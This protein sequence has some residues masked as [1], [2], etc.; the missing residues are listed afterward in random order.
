VW[1][2]VTGVTPPRGAELLVRLLLPPDRAEIVTGDLY[3]DFRHL[4]ESQSIQVAR[5]WYWRQV[6]ATGWSMRGWTV[7]RVWT[8]TETTLNDAR[9]AARVLLKRPLLSGT[10]ITT[11]ALGVGLNS[12]MFSVMDGVLLRPLP[13]MRPERLVSLGETH[14]SLP[15]SRVACYRSYTEW[16]DGHTVFS[17]VAATRPDEFTL[18]DHGE[19]E[20]VFGTRVTAS[21]FDVLGVRPLLGRGFAPEEDLPSGPKAIV[22]N[23]TLWRRRFG[24]D[25]QLVGSPVR[26]D[27]EFRRVVGI[28]PAAEEIRTLGWSDAW[29]PL[30]V[31]DA[32][33]RRNDG[34]WLLVM[35]RLQPGLTV[36]DADR[37]LRTARDH[38]AEDFPDSYR[39]WGTRVRP[40]RDVVVSS[41][42][43]VV[44][45]LFAAATLLLVLTCVN[46]AGL[47]LARSVDRARELALRAAIGAT[48]GRIIR[49]L[50]I[51]HALLSAAGSVAGIAVAHWALS[52]IKVR[53]AS[54]IPR[55]DG[56]HLDGGVLAFALGVAT[57]AALIFGVGPAVWTAS[58]ETRGAL[59]GGRALT[60][61]ARTRAVRRLLVVSQLALATVLVVGSLLVAG[62]LAE[63][64]AV[65]L[66]FEAERVLHV[67]L[68]LP[69]VRYA[70]PARQVA[71]FRGLLDQLTHQPT[72]TSAALVQF[73]PLGGGRRRTS[74]RNEHQASAN[75]VPLLV[76]FNVV[77]GD[78]F[79][80][81]HI[82]VQR[83]RPF[84][85]MEIW[86]G[87][88]VAIVSDA[89]ARRVFPDSDPVGQRI[90]EGST[91]SWR[92]VI[93]VVGDVRR[94][95][96]DGPP[97]PE[98]Y[99]PFASAPS[100]TTS[101]VVRTAGSPE[102]A[103]GDVRAIVHAFDPLLP[104]EQLTS[105]QVLVERILSGPRFQTLATGV[106]A[107]VALS[108]ALVGL[109]ALMAH[110]AATRKV[111][112][113]IRL[114]LGARPRS[115]LGD[116]LGEGAQLIA[117]GV[118]G[119][120]AG[121]VIIT[122]AAQSAL[123]EIRPL[124]ATTLAAAT[125]LMVVIGLTAC[126]VPAVR[127]L[128]T[129]VAGV[130]RAE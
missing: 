83:G 39:E 96:L 88:P 19:P 120:L 54:R 16:H 89:L 71:L 26:V 61:S 11:L 44:L 28:M 116:V 8:E 15:E 97:E 84:D 92:T 108:V 95:R 121:A 98:V 52:M 56:V 130:L 75:D 78:Y 80:V 9:I 72:I 48:R 59:M 6:L 18:E 104:V 112:F 77:S 30:A 102:T 128:R 22:L 42:R 129:D 49:Q 35:A 29:V 123:A 34:R 40:L 2:V 124:N 85:Q 36:F 107:V 74:V 65:R 13:F 50:M 4:A 69:A 87:A 41:A 113:G 122:R 81:M 93:G 106:S 58:R 126:V 70:D 125:I 45:L 20:R 67:S 100:R 27:G 33:E 7:G 1:E 68:A 103:V 110:V 5:R 3:E 60:G 57:L 109:Y 91:S 12:A 76:H 114:A 25:P 127:A 63:L 64:S 24:A 32:Q 86:R 51:E 82:P 115:V 118:G 53:A 117:V 101:L 10:V 21:Y 90:Q 47:L 111:E 37:F 62:T 73:P 23:E 31:D 105:Q 38:L 14:P 55:L 66:G 94:E 99:L 43:P 46:V 119:G 79:H 17:G